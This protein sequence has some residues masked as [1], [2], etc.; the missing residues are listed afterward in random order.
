[1]K[2][3]SWKD[4]LRYRFDH[5]MSQG[6]A[7]LMVLLF[8][9]TAVVV[10]ISGVLSALLDG[11]SGGTVFKSMWAS[12]MHALD[13]GTLAGD[14]GS[15]LFILLMTMVTV[16]GLFIT[17]MLIGIINAGIE[18]K[19]D[20]LRKGRSLVLEKNHVILLGFNENALNILRELIIANENQKDSAIVVMDDCDKSEME[21]LIHQRIK[22]MKTTRIICRSGRMDS[23]ADL[24]ICSPETCRS[25]IVNAADDFMTIKAILASANVLE[26]GGNTQA[27]ITAL[28]RDETHL[29]AAKIA[30]GGRAEV[31]YFQSTIA[32]IMAHTCRQPG[33]ST[34]FTDLL[35]YDGDEIYVEQISGA[36]GYAMAE[37]NLFFPHSTVIGIVRN[38]V[39]M[40]NPP[41]ETV[42]TEDDR[43]ILIA[44]DDGISAPDMQPATVDESAFAPVE[45]LK[46]CAQKTMILGC[47]ALLRKVLIE[48]DAYAAP[49][50]V[51]ILAAE[52]ERLNPAYLPAPSELKNITLDVRACNIFSRCELEALIN[53]YPENVLLLTDPQDED[54]EADARTLM[55][56]LHLREIARNH[57][58]V[59]T[60][61]SEMRSIQNQE[62]AQVTRVNDFVISSNITALMMAQISQTRKQYAVL[63]DLLDEE[64]SELYMKPASHYVVCDK[65]VDFYTVGAAAARYGEIAVGYKK[66]CADGDLNIVLNPPK[67]SIVTFSEKD[68]LIVIAEN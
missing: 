68:C 54:D 37:I 12:L 34:V 30:G 59:F 43:L 58:A 65:A 26:N 13:A 16:C 15:F 27:H 52:E 22:E 17:S 41:M 25:I 2:K 36:A 31:L 32:R 66:V 46:A 9:I 3:A 11:E 4:K 55:L 29:E 33:M 48:Q 50:S 20:S 8:A 45:E 10:V 67:K 28:I 61:T 53:E 56:L 40:V 64:G 51:V 35:G 6:T 47:N 57:P 1:M 60:V 62:L 42:I 49:G 39:A 38:D 21:E 18:S 24:T 14:E 63:E 7:S 5:L 44:W 19:M 23:F